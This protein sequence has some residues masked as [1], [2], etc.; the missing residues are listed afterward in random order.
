MRQFES[1]H[2]VRGT[3]SGEYYSCQPSCGGKLGEESFA[4][5]GSWTLSNVLQNPG[6]R[7]RTTNV[8]KPKAGGSRRRK[9]AV[10]DGVHA[11]VGPVRTRRAAVGADLVEAFLTSGAALQL[12]VLVWVGERLGEVKEAGLGEEGGAVVVHALALDNG[13][14]LQYCQNVVW[15]RVTERITFS[16]C[17]KRVA[18]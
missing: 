12:P 16:F 13:L 5:L 11:Y 2:E 8:V 9:L 17:R 7:Y 15:T 14:D 4:Y 6:I 10:G 1:S 18:I 3:L